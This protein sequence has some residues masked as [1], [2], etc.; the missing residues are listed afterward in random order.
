MLWEAR[1]G[2]EAVPRSQTTHSQMLSCQSSIQ[3]LDLENR[4]STLRGRHAEDESSVHSYE[5]QRSAHSALCMSVNRT[6][7]HLSTR[8][9]PM[10]PAQHEGQGGGSRVHSLVWKPVQGKTHLSQMSLPPPQNLS[11]SSTLFQGS[12]FPSVLG[13]FSYF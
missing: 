4:G 6:L 12:F 10:S 8:G 11:D 9:E 2:A 13:I 5:L 7:R 3:G 1:Q